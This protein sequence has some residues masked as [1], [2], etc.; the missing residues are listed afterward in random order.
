MPPDS[1]SALHEVLDRLGPSIF[2]GL[3]DTDGV[4][5]YANQGGAA[6]HRQLAGAGVRQA[7]RHHPLVA[8]LRAVATASTA[9]AGK[10][11][12]R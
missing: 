6:S 8:G 3:L 1:E 4:L 12:A 10:C 2:A 11:F 9:G 5:R 7:L